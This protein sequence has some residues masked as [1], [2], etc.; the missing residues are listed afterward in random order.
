MRL[1]F[2]LD[3]YSP[4]KK[5]VV[6]DSEMVRVAK[7]ASI[8][9]ALFSFVIAPLLQYAPEGLWQVMRISPDLQH[10]VI[11]IVVVG[12]YQRFHPWS[13]VIIFFHII[14]YLFQFIFND[15][16]TIHFIHLYAI[17]FSQR[18]GSC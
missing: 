7:V 16:I 9:I 10:T 2:C 15:L 14:T 6:T 12:L 5:G 18:W 11:A 4:L 17:L 3:I 1:H 8:F 13:K